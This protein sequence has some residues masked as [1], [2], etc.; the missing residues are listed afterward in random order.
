MKFDNITNQIYIIAVNEAKL[1]CHEYVTPEHF[2]YAM[3]LFDAGKN[4]LENCG[5]DVEKIENDLNDFFDNNLYKIENS[6]PIESFELINLFESATTYA[7]SLN[8]EIISLNDIITALF[9]LNESFGVY[10]LSKNGIKKNELLK[11]ISNQAKLKNNVLNSKKTITEKEYEYLE[12][13]TTEL[14]KRAYNNELDPLIGR[15]DVIERT[16]QV[17]SRRFKNN[18]V[19][20]GDPGV[21][22]TAI[23]EGVAQKIV[24][25]NVPDIIKNSKVYYLD[26]GSIIA[27]TKYRG[28]FEERLIK[29]LDIISKEKNPIIYI[30]EI[31]TI[32]GAGAVSGSTMDATSILKPYLLKSNLK[33]IGSTTY[34]EYKKYFEKDHALVRRFQKIEITEPSVAD[35]IKILNGI[36]QKYEIFHNVKYTD[37]AIIYACKLSDKYINDKHLPDKAID[38]ID[39]AGAYVK[40]KHNNN[41]QYEIG[42]DE[43]QHIVSMTAKIPIEKVSSDENEKL[44][45][46]NI[47]L[48]KE[49]FGQ[50]E[51]VEIVVNAIKASRSGL[52]DSEK[53]VA[54]LLFVGPTGVGK[55]EIAKQLAYSLGITL[56]RFDMS[57]YQGA[58]RSAIMKS[59]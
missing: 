6:E 16:M 54:S 11:Y 38:I 55:T 27:G 35:C 39:E 57:E 18:P 42:K 51:A 5:A 12:N 17:L 13:Y 9:N 28:D 21:G 34:S 36:K 44:K 52:N 8:K 37:E 53:P 10:I 25:G 49:I 7:V 46:L 22:K 23:V 59:I 41:C 58:T 20:V 14:T 29:V 43:I 45:N 15:E 32:V 31:H 4:I 19:H 30:D 3:I 47:Q 56:Q 26:M 50:D 24:S 2:I 40:L 1:Q 48:K 33:I